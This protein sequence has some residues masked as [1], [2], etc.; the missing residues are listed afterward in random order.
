MTADGRNE[1]I[2]QQL[3][4][5]MPYYQKAQIVFPADDP[6]LDQLVQMLKPTV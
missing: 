4:A 6:D 1:Y 2:R 3:A 5:R